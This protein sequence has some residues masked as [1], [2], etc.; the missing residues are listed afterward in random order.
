MKRV[1]AW[2]TSVM[3]ETP[4]GEGETHGICPP[5]IGEHFGNSMAAALVGSPSIQIAG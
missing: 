4:E 2:C 1:C 5:C 3:G